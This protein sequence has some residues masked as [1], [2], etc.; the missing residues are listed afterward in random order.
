MFPLHHYITQNKCLR[1]TSALF[2]L[3]LR[4]DFRSVETGSSYECLC[5]SVYI[6]QHE[7][8]IGFQTIEVNL[9]SLTLL[10]FLHC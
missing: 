2:S 4:D 3:S 7:Y 6:N 10:S 9:V 1:Q 8:F 5:L